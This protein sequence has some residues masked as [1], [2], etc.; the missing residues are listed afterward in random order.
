MHTI[1]KRIL[2]LTLTGG[3]LA[4]LS[5]CAGMTRGKDDFYVRDGKLYRDDD[6]FTLH[7]F[8]NAEVG[9]GHGT[10]A[11]MLPAFGAVAYVG[12]N[13]VCMDLAG[14]NADG[15]A[16]NAEDLATVGI[17][18]ER[19]DTQGMGV[20]VRVLGEST[21][22]DFRANAVKTAANALKN[23][24]RVAYWIDGDNADQLAA[25]FK[26]IAGKVVVACPSGCDLR[27]I[28]AVPGGQPADAVL[29]VDTLPDLESLDINFVVAG[30]EENLNVLDQALMHPEE[31]QP[32]T[33]DNSMLSEA[34]RAEG[35]VSLFNGKDLDGWYIRGENKE[36][37][38]VNEDAEIEWVSTDSYALLTTRR[39]DDFI[40]RLDHKILDGGNSGI[41]LRA[42]RDCR[43]SYIGMEFQLLGD[44]GTEPT[45]DT[46][47]ALYKQHP[48]LVVA[49]KPGGEWNTLEIRLEGTKIHAV[50][51]D[52]VIQD[53]DM[54]EHEDLAH[55]NKS[56]FIGLQDHDNYVAFRNIRIKEL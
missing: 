27:V 35:F 42:P 44:H 24:A 6:T 4:G 3:L 21:D 12:G 5:S 36:G 45:D 41:H 29:L 46:T 39:Y 2:F 25:D 30:T 17:L 16:I 38:R 47:G 34:E 1:V 8:K 15:T 32:W 14:F 55:R 37:F 10:K 18:A 9:A 50:L 40:L 43:N 26:A 49:S 33:P 54:A 48:P 51:N 20:L 7:A 23:E 56:G 22:P 31:K 13:T 52:Q 53:Y 19:A 28:D 11:T